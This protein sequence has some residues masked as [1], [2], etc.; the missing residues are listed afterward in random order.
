MNLFKRCVKL[1]KEFR[2]IRYSFQQLKFNENVN[3]NSAEEKCLEEI[4]L[5][6]YT[7]I[8]NYISEEECDRYCEEIDNLL[9]KGTNHVWRDRLKSD[10][11]LYGAELISPLIESFHSREELLNYANA[12]NGEETI[13]SHTLIGR[14]KYSLGNL[15]SGQG[16]HRDT[17]TPYQFKALLY[18]TDVDANCGPFQYIE[19]SHKYS[20]L[21]YGILKHDFD[22][23][24]TRFEQN[25]VDLLL[26]S[27][28]FKLKT[29][30]GKKGTLI[31]V[32]T[33]GLHRGMPIK[34]GMRYALTNYYFVKRNYKRGFMIKKFN[35]PI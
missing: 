34:K 15:G 10:E 9:K 14:L 17:A 18:L 16:W 8:E 1:L 27:K 26:A 23:S 21:F 31:L 33:F 35:L 29:L 7:V 3:L 24:Q 28:K 13:N 22:L 32:N 2:R 5:K 30:L 25:D 11:R 12:F 19:G 4:K 6:G 20:S